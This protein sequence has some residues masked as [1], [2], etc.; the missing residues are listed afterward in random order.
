M[1]W[2][3]IALSNILLNIDVWPTKCVIYWF[4]FKEFADT[5]ATTYKKHIKE[6]FILQGSC[7]HFSDTS[8]CY[9]FFLTNAAL[10]AGND[11][12]SLCQICILLW[13]SNT[14]IA[15]SP[16]R[17]VTDHCMQICVREVQKAEIQIQVCYKMQYNEMQ[18]KSFHRSSSQQPRDCGEWPR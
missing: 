9:R 3:S 13:I 5:G 10:V 8:P 18:P 4:F 16:T 7:Q 14:H 2:T 17:P 11:N 15:Q 12:H 1:S 6:K